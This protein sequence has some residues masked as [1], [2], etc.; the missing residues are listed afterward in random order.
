MSHSKDSVTQDTWQCIECTF[1][2]NQ[3]MLKCEMCQCPK[4]LRH[5]ANKTII[6]PYI[7]QDLKNA[8]TFYSPEEN[9]KYI[10]EHTVSKKHEE[11]SNMN[12]NDNSWICNAC[13][14]KNNEFMQICE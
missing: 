13:T 10:E 4:P 2:N 6:N 1:N 9:K 7:T 14:A 11:K 5:N 12:N 3:Y 8:Q